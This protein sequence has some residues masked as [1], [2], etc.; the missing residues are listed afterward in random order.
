MTSIANKNRINIEGFSHNEQAINLVRG[1]S[2]KELKGLVCTLKLVETYFPKADI[3]YAELANYKKTFSI[4]KRGLE[5]EK[6]TPFLAI[7]F[8]KDK[9]II[10]FRSDSQKFEE[11]VKTE[12][13]KKGAF[14][15]RGFALDKIANDKNVFDMYLRWLSKSASVK[16]KANG[17]KHRPDNYSTAIKQQKGAAYTE[18]AGGLPIPPK[19]IRLLERK[20]QDC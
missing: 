7:F 13:G 14:L 1:F 15:K 10:R 16:N 6:G 19:N 17:S 11:K 12:I 3:Y 4:G 8:Q 18:P 2:A 9:A 5:K 20:N